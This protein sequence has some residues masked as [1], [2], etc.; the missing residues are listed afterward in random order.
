MATVRVG[1]CSWVYPSWQGLVYSAAKEIDYLAE[2][3][4]HYDCVE[5]DRWFW[6]QFGLGKV[7]LP[8]AR[9][10]LAY[11]GAVPDTFRFG[12]KA[13]DSITLTHLRRKGKASPL[14][15]NPDFLSNTLFDRF[16]DRLGPLHDVLGPVMFQFEYLNRQKAASRSAF[17]DA[18]HDFARG[19][20]A[21][22][23]YGIE[24]RNARWLDASFIEFLRDVNLIPVLISGYWMPHL[25]D[26]FSEHLER[27][28]LFD[29]VIVRLMGQDRKTMEDATGSVWNTLVARHDR[30]LDEVCEALS[31]LA[32]GTTHPFLFVNNHY[33][34][35]APLT[36][37]R[38]RERLA[39]KP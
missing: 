32:G 17:L 34:G 29:T 23:T 15:G 24:I 28:R 20:P 13:P 3:A 12:V 27:L 6:S 10:V 25:A 31:S 37:E 33:E 7:R 11:R 38:I 14:I 2:Y 30:E 1:T 8:D 19:L 35:A 21:G 22:F 26:L 39:M 16:L 18:L 4:E 36:I 9:D 5:V